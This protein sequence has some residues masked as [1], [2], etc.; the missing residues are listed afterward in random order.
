M[1]E[2]KDLCKEYDLGI[3]KVRAIMNVSLRIEKG[4]FVTIMGPSGSGKSTLLH[5]LGILDLPTS[6]NY[7]LEGHDITCLPDRELSRIRN[8]HFGFVFQSFNLLPEFNAVDNVMMPLAYANVP[9]KDR[10]ARAREL[11]DR[12]GLRERRYHYPSMLSGGEQQRVAI[13]RALANDPDLILADEPTGNLPSAMGREILKMLYAL[14]EQGTTIVM[15]THDERLGTC[16]KRLI[17]MEDGRVLSDGPVQ[18][19]FNPEEA[20]AAP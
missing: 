6:G 1:I 2:V 5:L 20:H 8:Q 9:L 14:N 7:L 3:V 17:R 11:L 13:A 19:R 15:V 18:D 16:G 4:E 12:V 10:K